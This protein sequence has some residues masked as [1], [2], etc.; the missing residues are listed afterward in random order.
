MTTGI[1]RRLSV[2]VITGNPLFI[3][4]HVVI[5]IGWKMNERLTRLFDDQRERFEAKLA[6][7]TGI[8]E[9]RFDEQDKQI[10]ELKSD[11]RE[12]RKDLL[13]CCI[14]SGHCDYGKGLENAR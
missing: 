8:M 4:V 5:E 10:Q 3:Y 11:I 9:E 6:R 13:V 12:Y 7:V 14:Y 1:D 2:C